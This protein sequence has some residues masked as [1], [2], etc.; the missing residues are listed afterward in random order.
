MPLADI[1][2]PNFKLGE[3][4]YLHGEPVVS[5]R[6]R[7]AP[8]DFI[9]DEELG[10][11]PDPGNQ[12]LWL[13]ISKQLL[14]TT[15][16]ASKI[17]KIA[18]IPTRD[19]G[20]SGL[21][22]RNAVTSQWFSLP[23]RDNIEQ[24]EAIL[25]DRFDGHAQIQLDQALPARIKLKRGAHRLNAFVI[26]IRDLNGP[27]SFL[28]ERLKAICLTGVPNYF[29]DQ[30]FGRNGNN[31]MTALRLFDNP[32]KKIDRIGRSMALSSARSWLFN[33]VLSERLRDSD[34][35]QVNIGDVMQL[36][37][38]NAWFVHDGSDPNV[39][40]RVKQHDLHLTGPL[41]G[42]GQLPTE[43]SIVEFE[44]GVIGQYPKFANGLITAGLQQQR[45]ALRL[46]PQQM[47][48]RFVGDRALKINFKL[49]RGS[50]ATSV[51]REIAKI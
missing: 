43:N 41:W 37:G 48:W 25:R 33:K 20:Y 21:K 15:E 51:L 28:E 24:V 17:A 11:T 30:R 6:I 39:H 9:V 19:V 50:F 47:H 40:D 26:T 13:N 4:C 1:E 45:R 34:L 18:G 36:N 32:K 10:F 22:D 12:H 49:P 42:E 2:P 44:R 16:V 8:E 3:W 27:A 38:T 35:E 31:L 46:V 14:N 23:V 5:G 29:G 7:S